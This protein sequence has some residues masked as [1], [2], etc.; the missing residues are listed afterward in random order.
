MSK[1][2]IS[3]NINDKNGS[4]SASDILLERAASHESQT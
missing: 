2:R 1:I 3:N 4:V